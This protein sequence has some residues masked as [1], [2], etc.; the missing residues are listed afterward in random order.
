[1]IHTILLHQ[2]SY[3]NCFV[4]NLHRNHISAAA[5]QSKATGK[6]AVR[7]VAEDGGGLVGG[8]WLDGGREEGGGML[9][10]LAQGAGRVTPHWKNSVS[11]SASTSP[12][13][14]SSWKAITTFTQQPKFVTPSRVPAEHSLEQLPVESKASE[15]LTPSFSTLMSSLNVL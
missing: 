6:R 1:M 15:Q 3:F 5:E 4:C 2:A 13:F 8:A 7:L 9:N 10:L 12:V 11:N 14:M